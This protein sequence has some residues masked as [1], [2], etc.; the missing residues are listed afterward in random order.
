M[1]GNI[2]N[3]AVMGMNAQSSWL[4]TIS[5]NIANSSTTGYKDAETEFNSLVDQSSPSNYSAGGVSTTR[6]GGA[7][8]ARP[9][10]HSPRTQT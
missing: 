9:A 5:Q 3:A 8:Y 4:A 10:T 6:P 1:S 2:M 7:A